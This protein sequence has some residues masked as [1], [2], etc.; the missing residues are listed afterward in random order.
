MSRFYGSLNGDRARTP[1][2]RAGHRGIYGHIRNWSAG[3]RVELESRPEGPDAV[4]VFLT[5]G[6]QH[7]DLRRLILE[8]DTDSVRQA[9]MEMPGTQVI[10]ARITE[11]EGG[12]V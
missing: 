5:G 10:A 6:S 3:V 12:V 1:A 8:T 2:T 9:V 7:P 4:R 11:D